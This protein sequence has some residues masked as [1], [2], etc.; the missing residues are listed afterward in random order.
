M[1]RPA[2]CK[3]CSPLPKEDVDGVGCLNITDTAQV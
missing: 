1:V 3:L 2:L